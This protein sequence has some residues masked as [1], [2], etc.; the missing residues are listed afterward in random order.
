MLGPVF[1]A[2]RDSPG[3]SVPS[4][5]F[6]SAFIL[7][8]L[9]GFPCL[10]V[11]SPSLECPIR[12]SPWLCIPGSPRGWHLCALELCGGWNR[13]SSFQGDE[14]WG[15]AGNCGCGLKLRLFL[16]PCSQALG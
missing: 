8:M 1:P 15:E 10:S 2:Q 11:F 6:F 16:Q 4:P 5:G 3:L 12:S 9:Q 13:R 14:E 7:V